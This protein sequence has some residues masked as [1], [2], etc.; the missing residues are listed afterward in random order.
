[1]LEMSKLVPQIVRDYDFV[2]EGAGEWE[3]INFWFVKPMNFKVKVKLREFE[4]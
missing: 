1:M 2:L 3:T 4:R